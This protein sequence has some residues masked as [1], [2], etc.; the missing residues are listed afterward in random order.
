MTDDNFYFHLHPLDQSLTLFIEESSTISIAF[1]LLA[2]LPFDPLVTL[3]SQSSLPL[4]EQM[5]LVHLLSPNIM[6][7]HMFL[8]LNS[9]MLQS[10][11]SQ[12]IECK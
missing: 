7:I 10:T 6:W 8:N 1:T 11:R 4:E 9:C 3:Y 5:F 2:L 12:E